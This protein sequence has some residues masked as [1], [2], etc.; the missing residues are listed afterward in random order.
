MNERYRWH[1]C[2]QI[3]EIAS[4]PY[5]GST[6]SEKGTIFRFADF[7]RAFLLQ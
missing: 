7:N 3:A 6:M 5:D 2:Q 1:Q 4:E